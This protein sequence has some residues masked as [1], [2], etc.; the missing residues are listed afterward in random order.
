MQ[1]PVSVFIVDDEE[2][3]INTLTKLLD[4]FFD[5]VKIVGSAQ[6]AIDAHKKIK[7]LKPELVFLDIEMGK[8]SGFDLLETF[9]E[10]DFQV[11]FLTAHEEYALKAIKF[12]A[13]DYIIKPARISELK[14]LFDKTSKSLNRRNQG[15]NI[16]HMFGNFLTPNKDE[17]KIALPITEGIEFKKVKTILYLT[18]DGSYCHLHLES[19][20]TLIV[21]KNLKHFESILV[22]YG[23]FRIHNSTLINLKHVKKVGRS[24]GGYVVME[25]DKELS[26]SKSRKEK[27]SRVLSI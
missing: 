24:S 11:V 10:V 8:E 16:K 12:S 13:I 22:E 27:F 6:N 4:N 2:Y 15:K 18:A 5:N 23:F 26:I 17:H 21:S 9:D 25:N 20:E 1:A 7:E 3:A 14:L 19:G